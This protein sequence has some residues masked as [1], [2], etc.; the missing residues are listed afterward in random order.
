MR[1]IIVIFTIIFLFTL[2]SCANNKSSSISSSSSFSTSSSKIILNSYSDYLDAKPGSY[3]TLKVVVK[4]ASI[5][6]NK[7]KNLETTLDGNDILFIDFQCTEAEANL[8]V[9]ETVFIARGIKDY[10][11]NKV[12]IVL[13]N[14]IEIIGKQ[15]E[16]YSTGN[17]TKKVLITSTTALY[18]GSKGYFNVIV[19]G[20]YE[21]KYK[22]ALYLYIF[23][24]LPKNYYHLEEYTSHLDE[25][26]TSIGGD[27]YETES[28]YLSRDYKFMVADLDNSSN[29]SETKVSR[30]K[31]Q[32]V[33][34]ED[35]SLVYFTD[36]GGAT[37]SI[38][39]FND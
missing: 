19:S 39:S 31:N 28:P 2:T 33:Y 1:K 37:F 13:G 26:L 16:Y 18:D 6:T 10:E 27:T 5:Y 25:F 22:V 38:I 35:C 4:R 30:S 20:K 17:L 8:L 12:Q 24:R 15:G 32:L 9:P 7:I 3:L 36:D 11:D 29:L 14:V 21:D 34:S 23:K